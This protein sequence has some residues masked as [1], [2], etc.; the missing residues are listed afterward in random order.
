MARWNPSAEVGANEAIG[1]R[2]FDEPMLVGARDQKPYAGLVLRHFQEKRSEE[3]SI[4]RLGRSNIEP[5]VLNYLKPRA[6]LAGNNFKPP[7]SFNGW[8][9]LR[10]RQLRQ[11]PVGTGFPVLSSPISGTDLDEN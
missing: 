10:A 9:V 6:A 7:K 8:A 3:F 5:A 1:R 4:D 11:P 2:L